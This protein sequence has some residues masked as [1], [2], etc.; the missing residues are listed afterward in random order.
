MKM[1]FASNEPKGLLNISEQEWKRAKAYFKANPASVKL[2]RR[3]G[4]AEEQ[5]F[6][7]VDGQIY[8]LASSQ[9]YE[10]AILGEGKFSR[11]KLAQQYGTDKIVAVKI[12]G[13]AAKDASDD[14]YMISE[15]LG[16]AHGQ[17][18]RR[19]DEPRLYKD[20]ITNKK[21]YTITE[22]ITG[23]ELSNVLYEDPSNTIEPEQFLILLIKTSV[24]LLGLHR[25]GVIHGDIKEQNFMADI[26]GYHILVAAIDFGFSK[27][28]EEDKTSLILDRIQGTPE[29]MAPEIVNHGQYSFASDIF[30]LGKMYQY[31]YNFPKNTLD[32]FK[33]ILA[34]YESSIPTEESRAD[35]LEA[36]ASINESIEDWTALV[37]RYRQKIDLPLGPLFSQMTEDNPNLRP[38]LER[39]IECALEQLVDSHHKMEEARNPYS[40]KIAEFIRETRDFLNQSTEELSANRKKVLFSYVE[41]KFEKLKI[42]SH[43]KIKSDLLEVPEEKEN[44]SPHL[45]V[46]AG[47]KTR[48]TT[49]PKSGGKGQ[50]N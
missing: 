15:V 25:L 19:L 49:S 26:Q 35:H 18:E 11:V 1:L 2:A 22:Y 21:F 44:T 47:R 17:A 8:C 23:D 32:E 43:G 13:I 5:S 20:V 27:I 40:D 10:K 28:I 14:A 31:I 24:V 29:Y 7:K 33:T 42:K 16:F 6:I 48:K 46:K 45:N 36:I 3:K 4:V 37:E 9:C 12:E 30:A 34:E 41:G 39:V 50:R 38:N